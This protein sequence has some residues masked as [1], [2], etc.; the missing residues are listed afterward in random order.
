M[1]RVL[2]NMVLRSTFGPKR[3]EKTGVELITD[4]AEQ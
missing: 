2:E 3:D 1:L 4:L